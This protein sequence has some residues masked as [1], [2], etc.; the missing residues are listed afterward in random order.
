MPVRSK[1]EKPLTESK[2][3]LKS[4][5]RG[6]E[7]GCLLFRSLFLKILD[8]QKSSGGML[9]KCKRSTGLSF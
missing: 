7:L 1:K 5:K 3:G 6:I 8:R 2:E 4:P 9:P